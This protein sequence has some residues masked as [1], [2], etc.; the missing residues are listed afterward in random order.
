MITENEFIAQVHLAKEALQQFIKITT[1]KE[2]DNA[3][4]IKRGAME[5][6][7]I[8]MV[9]SVPDFPF[10]FYSAIPFLA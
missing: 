8:H 3:E 1:S 6:L 5:N 2:Y 7:M 10:P 4:A 9:R